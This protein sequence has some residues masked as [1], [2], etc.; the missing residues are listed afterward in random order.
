[1]I[2][3]YMEK[4]ME[5]ESFG[6]EIDLKKDERISEI[7]NGILDDTVT[8]IINGSVVGKEIV[9]LTKFTESYNSNETQQAM[10]LAKKYFDGEGF[11]ASVEFFSKQYEHGDMLQGYVLEISLWSNQPDF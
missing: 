1:M 11:P 6:V 2:Y 7:Y 5:L 9:R 3:I 10:L 8:D 4:D